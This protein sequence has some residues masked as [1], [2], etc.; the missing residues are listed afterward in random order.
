MLVDKKQV[1]VQIV[2]IISLEDDDRVNSSRGKYPD[3]GSFQIEQ[4][5]WLCIA[6][7]FFA[8]LNS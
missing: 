3:N 8:N 2:I 1:V 4:V 6:K 7:I 5:Y